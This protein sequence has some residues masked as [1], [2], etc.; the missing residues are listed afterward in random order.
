MSESKRVMVTGGAGFIGSTVVDRLVD[1]GHSVTAVDNLSSGKR[2]NLDGALAGGR[3]TLAEIDIRSAELAAC[4]ADVGPEVIMHLAA[5]VDVRVSVDDPMLDA[6]INI[7]GTLNLLECARKLTPMPRLVMAFSAAIYGNAEPLPIPETHNGTPESP[8]GISKR[9]FKDYLAYYEQTYGLAS[10]AL[11]P[12]NVYGPRQDPFGEGGVVAIFLRAMLDGSGPAIFGDGSQ[13]RDF[14]FV[15]DVA[16]AFARAA[17]RG[18]GIYNVGTGIEITVVDLWNAC[19]AVTGYSGEVRFVPPRAG[20][21]QRSVLDAGRA[22]AELGWQ[23]RTDLA[24]GL[25]AT[26]DFI[27]GLIDARK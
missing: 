11:T 10:V 12:A 22:R 26:R 21:I 14:V 17:E 8:Y 16:D 3:V 20:E 13:T 23:P 2:A 5:Q 18:A 7:V 6:G 15:G 27:Q 19:A 1:D 25:A 4:V 9:V 24:D